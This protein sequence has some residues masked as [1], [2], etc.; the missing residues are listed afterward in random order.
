MSEK[1]EISKDVFENYIKRELISEFVKDLKLEK[2][3]VKV[4]SRCELLIEQHI[5]K[6]EDILK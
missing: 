1:P 5:K 6:W 3:W 2:V 4:D